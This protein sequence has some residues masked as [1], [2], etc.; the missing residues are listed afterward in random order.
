MI[1]RT[2]FPLSRNESPTS[3]CCSKKRAAKVHGGA[4][5]SIT[6]VKHRYVWTGRL[7]HCDWHFTITES[8]VFAPRT[9][10]R[11]ILR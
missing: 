11:K 1:T 8:G 7:S 10:S 9:R 2:M 6:W 4:L 5:E 3:E